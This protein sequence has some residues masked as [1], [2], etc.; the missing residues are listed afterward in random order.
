MEPVDADGMESD[1]F[2][3]ARGQIKLTLARLAQL[4]KKN[5]FGFDLPRAEICFISYMLSNQ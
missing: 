1:G 3:Q 4:T 5:L 2:G